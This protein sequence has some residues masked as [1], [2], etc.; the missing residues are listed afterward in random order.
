MQVDTLHGHD[1][2]DILIVTSAGQMDKLKLNISDYQFLILVDKEISNS[3]AGVD[4]THN[5]RE[6]I[7]VRHVSALKRWVCMHE[8]VADYEAYSVLA[9]KPVI[10]K[11]EITVKVGT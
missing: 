2:L 1:P 6:T 8:K 10:V 11:Q 4:Y 3:N 9:I 5:Y 7:Y